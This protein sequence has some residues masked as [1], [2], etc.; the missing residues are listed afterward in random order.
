MSELVKAMNIKPGELYEYKIENKL[1]IGRVVQNTISW[2]GSYM[3]GRQ[4]EFT[5]LFDNN[6]EKVVE[7]D[8][9][10]LKIKEIKEIKKHKKTK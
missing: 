7:W 1:K 2:N 5:I 6:D 9:Q 3:G 8:E 10:M 4:T